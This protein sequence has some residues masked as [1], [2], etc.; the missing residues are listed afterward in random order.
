M[1]FNRPPNSSCW[2]TVVV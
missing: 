2:F 1:D